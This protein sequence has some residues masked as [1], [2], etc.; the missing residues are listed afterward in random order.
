MIGESY[1]K[2]GQ[3]DKALAFY[4]R[5]ESEFPQSEGARRARLKLK[6]P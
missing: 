4:R 6:T 1:E 2:L 5:T 3:G